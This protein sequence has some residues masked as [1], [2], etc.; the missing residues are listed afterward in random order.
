MIPL[1]AAVALA[2]PLT[3]Q[4]AIDRALAANPVVQQS[5][6]AESIAAIQ[7]SRAR[8]DRYGLTLGAVAGAS[9]RATVPLDGGSPYD[10]QAANWDVRANAV[11]P[12]YQGGAIGARIDQSAASAR[13]QVID[14]RITERDIARAVVLAY[15]NVQGFELQRE[16]AQEA[17]AVTREALSVIEARAAAGIAAQIDVNRSR[18]DVFQQEAQLLDLEN[19]IFQGREEL[20]RLLHLES[21]EVVLVEEV[22]EL[23]EAPLLAIPAVDDPS[24]A[25]ATSAR[26]ELAQ[27][28]EI[29]S[30]AEAEVRLARSAALP[31]LS[32][33]GDVG[34]GAVAAGGGSDE[35]FPAPAFDA[36]DL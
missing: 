25:P 23:A 30:A 33:T 21:R 36:D 27:R 10:A 16:A 6:I 35:L 34:I 32:L 17:L 18:V 19:G 29:E 20:A 12:L 7:L 9:E 1:L 13:S 2:E 4:A 8:L 26:L 5:A 22:P 24:L 31:Q 11:L 3:V 14:R 28:V 15:F